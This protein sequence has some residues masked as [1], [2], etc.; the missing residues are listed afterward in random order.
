MASAGRERADWDD[1]EE[2]AGAEGAIPFDDGMDDSVPE[3]IPT[4]QRLEPIHWLRDDLLPDS[5]PLIEGFLHRHSF[6]CLFGGS[7]S[8]KSFVAIDLAGCVATGMRWHGRN[9]RQGAIV[10]VAPDGAHGLRQ[11]LGA[12]RRHHSPAPETP[13]YVMAGA[14]DLASSR[15]V[16]ILSRRIAALPGTASR[17]ELIVVDTLSRAMGGANENGSEGMGAFVAN[18]DRL[19]AATGACVLVVHHTGKQEDAGARGHSLFR[20]ALDTEARI[21]KTG[22]AITIEVS[23]QRDHNG[24]GAFCAKLLEVECAGPGGTVASTCVAIAAD[25]PKPELKS[26]KAERALALLRTC[27]EEKG[28][29]SDGTEGAPKGVTCVTLNEWRHTLSCDGQINPQGSGREQF[30]RIRVTLENAGFIGIS[31]EFVWCVT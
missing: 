28:R 2:D 13:F 23:K 15:D 7:G 20:A 17:P 31:G 4:V 9:V 25:A 21:T 6:A 14:I 26:A 24:G 12:W 1:D 29:V 5:E 18:C 30:K 8:G 11:R 22:D 16:E 19:R 27:L 3:D 10:F